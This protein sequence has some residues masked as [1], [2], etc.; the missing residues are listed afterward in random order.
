[1]MLQLV[2]IILNSDMCMMVSTFFVAFL[3]SIQAACWSPD[4]KVLV[5]SVA[6]EPALYSLQFQ[7]IGKHFE[8]NSL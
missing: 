7:N 6:N 1:M 5:F 4:G 8:K 3:L 2:I